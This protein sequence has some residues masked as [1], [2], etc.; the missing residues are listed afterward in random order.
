[1][2]TEMISSWRFVCLH[3]FKALLKLKLL[4]KTLFPCLLTLFE[5]K[6]QE[7][8]HRKATENP[9]E[10]CEVQLQVQKGGRKLTEMCFFVTLV[11]FLSHQ[12]RADAPGREGEAAGRDLQR[13]R[14]T[15]PR[16]RRPA[17]AGQAPVR[18]LHQILPSDQSQGEGHP[19]RKDH[20]QISQFPLLFVPS[21]FPSQ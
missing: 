16:I 11:L 12:V 13:Y 9:N 6:L 7:L 3:F 21:F 5:H 20:R 15:E 18:L 4:L 1:M 17:R 14:P 10:L 19:H 2:G 8:S